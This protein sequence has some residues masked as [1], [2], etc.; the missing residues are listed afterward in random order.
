MAGEALDVFISYSHRDAGLKD[1]LVN[2]PL[3]RLQRQGKINTWRDCTIE[4]GTEWAEEV[5]TNLEKA[6]IVLLLVTRH[7]LAADCYEKE[8][9]RVVQ[10]HYEGAVSYPTYG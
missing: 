9:R 8:M 4:S 3:K 2:Y 10:R 6:D 1:E 7:F 5:R